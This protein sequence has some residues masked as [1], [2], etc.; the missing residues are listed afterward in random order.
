MYF[1]CFIAELRQ[2]P[3]YVSVY[4][5]WM[6]LI[7]VELVPYCGILICNFLLIFTICRSSSRITG[8]GTARKHR[9]SNSAPAGGNAVNISGN[10]TTNAS[11]GANSASKA[12][13][14]AV[15]REDNGDA[16]NHARASSPVPS[17]APSLLMAT[18]HGRLVEAVR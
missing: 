12:P 16:N 9:R 8:A 13:A 10:A 1:L 4:I 6:K 15:V 3:I 5:F 2:N 18:R 7:L 14:V 17:E 11:Y